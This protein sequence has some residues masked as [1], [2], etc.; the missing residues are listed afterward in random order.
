MQRP[1][2]GPFQG[3]TQT[4]GMSEVYPTGLLTH[5]FAFVAVLSMV[6][7][8]TA[9]L[10]ASPHADPLSIV[11]FGSAV[12]LALT[13][14]GIYTMRRVAEGERN[15]F[16]KTYDVAFRH[17]AQTGTRAVGNIPSEDPLGGI[18]GLLGHLGLHNR[19]MQAQ[20][21]IEQSETAALHHTCETGLRQAQVAASGIR[22]DAGSLAETAAELEFAADRRAREMVEAA[23]SLNQTEAGVDN[24]VSRLAGLAGSVRAITASADQM[25]TATADFSRLVHSARDQIIESDGATNLLMSTLDTIEHAMQVVGRT[26]HS[27]DGD[28]A[29]SQA[30]GQRPL[31]TDAEYREVARDCRTA[32]ERAMVVI[33]QMIVQAADADRRTVTISHQILSMREMGDAIGHAVKQQSD[34]IAQILDGFYETRQG[35]VTLRTSIE[36]VTGLGQ[37]QRDVAEAL[38]LTATR[39]PARAESL[40]SLMRRLPDFAP[41]Q[42]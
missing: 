31:V 16:R 18:A 20:R 2:E 4:V 10:Y 38:R 8:T 37:S 29:S 23:R 15:M 28:T 41:R 17:S 5:S 39:L 42:N 33:G 13:L 12:L 11:A 7:V 34:D 3:S 25:A 30:D 40:V 1:V 36:K 32:L 22:Q 35:F 21:A 19:K 6:V 9:M 26:D 27:I 24:A 14:T